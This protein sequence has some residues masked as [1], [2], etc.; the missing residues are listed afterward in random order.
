MDGRR[1]GVGR[2]HDRGGLVSI[3]SK[4]WVSRPQKRLRDRMKCDAGRSIISLASVRLTSLLLPRGWIVEAL[5]QQPRAKVLT[6]EEDLRRP[7]APRH[8]STGCMRRGSLHAAGFCMISLPKSYH[9]FLF[10]FRD[11]QCHYVPSHSSGSW[12]FVVGRLLY[13]DDIYFTMC[14]APPAIQ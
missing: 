8:R 1:V 2:P 5:L 3:G 13:N 14:F 7:P 6:N 11:T 4:G 12:Q 9:F 10:G